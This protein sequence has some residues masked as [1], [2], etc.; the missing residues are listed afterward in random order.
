MRNSD[1]HRICTDRSDYP[2]SMAH[3]RGQTDP[4]LT[5]RH[6]QWLLVNIVGGDVV[7]TTV[8][9]PGTDLRRAFLNALESYA[10]EGWIRE[11]EPTYPCVFMHRSGE[12]RVLTI[13]QLDPQGA[14]L[15]HF[16]PWDS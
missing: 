1:T 8:L 5:S 10:L 2:C 7:S 16:S 3:R 15:R 4:F 6:A 12:R 9:E 11:N 13:C 14:P